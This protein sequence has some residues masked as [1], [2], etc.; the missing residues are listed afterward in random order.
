M[1]QHPD[2]ASRYVP[3]QDEPQEAVQALTPAGKGGLGLEEVMVDYEGKVTPYH[4]T[5]QIAY[6]LIQAGV[7]PGRDVA[8]TPRLPSC[9]RENVFRQMMVFMSALEANA[10]V[11][12]QSEVWAVR[13]VILPMASQAKSLLDTRRRLA[14]VINLAHA[15]L[16]L[17]IEP[18]AISLIP[19][20]EEVPMLVNIK[21]IL[22]SY[23]SLCRL[24]GFRDQRIR[25]MLGR[26][27]P[28]LSYGMVAAV[29][30]VKLALAACHELA[31]ERGVPIAPIAGF[32]ALPFRGHLTLENLDNFL[33]DYPGMRTAAVQSGLRYDHG[34]EK[35]RRLAEALR[36]RLPQSEPL[37]FTKEERAEIK[38]LI[39]LFSLTYLQVFYDLPPYVNAIA[40][41]IPSQRDRLVEKKSPIGYVRDLPRPERLSAMTQDEEL[42]RQLQ[43]LPYNSVDKLP[44]AIKYTAALYTIG[45]PPEFIGTGRGLQRL[46]ERSGEEGLA[47]LLR[48]YPGL[49]ADLTFAARYVNLDIARHFLP[50]QVLS[51]LEEDT[52]IVA[53]WLDIPLGPNCHEDAYYHTILEALRP[54][55]KDLL[56]SGHS[57]LADQGMERE[58]ITRWIKKLG[59]LRGSL[60]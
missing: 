10:I 37:S 9:E 52:R 7:V 17:P 60:G 8:I 2:S 21:P 39:A 24:H 28:A 3:V 47:R 22:D 36:E 15:E 50:R 57:L 27:D 13:E 1:L 4:Q 26:S 54:M 23:I 42:A 35:T 46:K 40:D 31:Q 12:D 51:L 14:D 43:K 33:A 30:A 55:L 16:D 53:Q 59:T 34:P 18:N 11:Y 29:L 25:V 6:G 5:A 58:L 32:G 48:F 20:F 56:N 38:E 44:R 49:V 19:L 45:L 41:F